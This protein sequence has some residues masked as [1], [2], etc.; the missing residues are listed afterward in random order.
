MLMKRIMTFLCAYLLIG[1]NLAIAQSL[2]VSGIVISADDGEPVIGA[3]VTVNDSKTGTTTNVD[4]KFSLKV[5]PGDKLRISYIGMQTQ[6]L[7]AASSMRVV[8]QSDAQLID[9][10]VVTGMNKMDKRLFTGASDQLNADD[11][12]L[13]GMA[14]ISRSLEGRSAG[15]SVQNVSATFG[16][17]PKIRIRG[18]TSILGTSKPLWVVDGVVMEDVTEISPTDLTSGDAET[19][20]SSAIAGLNAD[21]IESFNI[22]KDGSATSIYG[23]KAMAGV[24]VVTT[25]K[26]RAGSTRLSYTG[27]FTTRMK[28]S[29]S[30]YNVLNSQDQMSVFAEMKSKGWLNLSETLR[31]SS[32]GVYGKM[33]NL[34]NTY[35]ST[36]GQF[37]LAYTDEA[38]NGYLR[39]AEYRNTDWFDEL[40]SNSLMM[41]HSVSIST[42][43]ERSASY[44]SMS[45]MGDPGWY[46]QSSVKRYT[47]NANT[48]F[49]FTDRLSFTLLGNAS[50]RKQH[51]PGTMSQETDE[52]TGEVH[53]SFDINPFYYALNTS[54][55]MAAD[56]DYTR[57]Y[58]SF[59]VFDELENNYIEMNVVDAKFQAELNWTIIPGLDF[60]SLASY[61]YVSSSNQHH[62]KDESNQARAY[63]EMSDATIRDKNPFLYDDPD[64]LNTEPVSILPV[65]GIY[66]KR[67]YKTRSYTV[68]NSLTW[69][70]IFNDT[71]I[72][73]A[74][75]GMEMT[76]V[77][78]TNDWFRGW[79]LLYDEG[80]MAFFDYLAFKKASEDGSDYF[81]LSN[82]NR[83]TLAYYGT[84]NYSYKGKYNVNG[85]LRYEGTNR[86]GQA[87]SAR[88]LPTWNVGA[89]WNVHEEKFFEALRPTLS[90]LNLKASYSLTADA[91][92]DYISNSM[93]IIESY[94]PW[95]PTASDQESG[96]QI[97]SLGN[98]SLTYEKKHEL[99]L[100]LSV[101][102]LDNRI[103]LETDFYWRNNYDLLGRA[104][105]EGA[106]GE[107]LKYA[108]VADMSARG[109]E[110]TL[111]T[112]NIKTPDFNWHTDLTFSWS[113]QKIK[114]LQSDANMMDL[115]VGTGYNMEGYAP[116]SLF[117]IPFVG[118]DSDGLPMFEIGGELITQA[119]YDAI[120]FQT[121]DEEILKS[122]KYEGPTDPKVTGGFGNILTYKNFRLNIFMTYAFG[123]KVRL[124]PVFSSSYSDFDA[125]P[126][127]FK[128]RWMVS[129]DE[130]RTNIPVIASVR[131]QEEI[132]RSDL[133]AAYNSYNYSTARVGKGDFIRMKEISLTYDFPKSWIS[134]ARLTNLSLKAQVTNPF[135]IYTH[136]SM[137]GQ[138]PEYY[139]S[140]GVSSPLAR[141]FTFTI[142]AGF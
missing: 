21:D 135:L 82:T 9:E 127:E 90:H 123:S 39:E 36:T 75:G 110:F 109:M 2:Q 142:R 120:N 126:G 17:A 60:S 56:E 108:N 96:L 59:N 43:T 80:E 138:D 46:K 32:S 141:Q 42:G 106:G 34:I 30:D 8:L 52:V 38:M 62:I 133:A 57:N 53:R 74:Y 15:V 98:S 122:L 35:N 105:T 54:R 67:E 101:G 87:T 116:Y 70:K 129:G 94:T 22:L 40:F 125:M 124:N 137:N 102:F 99:N 89:A 7:Q 95:R 93:A 5:N 55:T 107:I 29:Y 76:S 44:F 26:G 100:G 27:E 66:E 31:A 91:G 132:G 11:V 13:N 50:Y 111:S 130:A 131:Q 58:T 134:K 79:G 85:T 121:T 69:N 78:R 61:R 12:L 14:D 115:I 103:N 18:A 4:G 1:I 136:D 24:I 104:N 118:L 68:R 20:I 84:V 71:H 28:P 41:N 16:T 65:G 77:A 117:S 88:W 92:P 33:Y 23:A 81:T 97:T 73:N 114:N 128:N 112:H 63:R 45:Y 140:G 119:N 83:R 48:K 6:V 49:N 86:L 51:A 72:V 3:S 113:K 47:F 64:E 19:L 25:K 10:V 37:G 139:S